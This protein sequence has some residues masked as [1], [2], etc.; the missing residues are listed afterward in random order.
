MRRSCRCRYPRGGELYKPE[1]IEKTSIDFDVYGDENADI[2]LITYGRLFSYACRAKEQLEKDGINIKIIK[3]CRIKPIDPK[4]VELASL[5]EQQAYSSLR[6]LSLRAE[7]PSR[8]AMSSK[9]A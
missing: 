2:A 1:D 8:S 4:A 3:L 9:N 5:K 7:S 6:N